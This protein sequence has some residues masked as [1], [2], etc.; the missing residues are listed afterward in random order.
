MQT[1]VISLFFIALAIVS[2]LTGFS[3]RE[4]NMPVMWVLL[5]LAMVVIVAE[6]IPDKK[7]EKEERDTQK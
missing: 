5:I 2:V 7:E 1:R 4:N 6:F 3:M